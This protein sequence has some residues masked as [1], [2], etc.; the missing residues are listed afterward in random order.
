MTQEALSMVEREQEAGRSLAGA[1]LRVL[2]GV[3]RQSALGLRQALLAAGLDPVP[4]LT[5]DDLARY[6]AE[7]RGQVAVAASTFRGLSPQHLEELR[8]L[9]LP[10]L[11]LAPEEEV[12]RFAARGFVALP[13]GSAAEQVVEALLALAEGR[14]RPS[15]LAAPPLLT[16]EE[17]E[18]EGRGLFAAVTG[19]KGGSGK[20][21]L[22]LSLGYACAQEG[23]QACVLSLDPVASD[24]QA[25]LGLQVAWGI[26]AAVG[27]SDLEQAVARELRTVTKGFDVLCGPYRPQGMRAVTEEIARRV[28]AFLRR[29]YDVVIADV[30]NYPTEHRA[31]MWAIEAADRLLV[32]ITPELPAVYRAQVAMGMLTALR[33]ERWA[34]LV[35]CRYRGGRHHWR[36]REVEEELGL[37]VVGTVPEDAA[38]CGKALDRLV[39]LAAVG[40]R[41][42][43]AL[44]KLA[45]QVLVVE[46]RAR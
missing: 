6:A 33:G 3:D 16:E 14:L 23:A 13:L 27:A 35:I 21:T 38:A 28:V 19:L 26:G 43:A 17:G 44:R 31:A 20:T 34:G 39:P 10:T 1:G 46:A 25:Y 7:G 32:A 40:G 30:G 24:I 12:G 4:A 41:A 36:A 5:A 45:R 2:L 29:R 8:S 42:A 18:E 37:P 11:V 22:A 15:A 9:G